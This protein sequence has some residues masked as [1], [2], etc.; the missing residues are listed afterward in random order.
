MSP[1][2]LPP[3]LPANALRCVN[4]VLDVVVP[5]TEFEYALQ[6][7]LKTIQ[8]MREV[9]MPGGVLVLAD[10]GMGKTLLLQVLKRSLSVDDPLLQTSRPV[11]EISL[12]SAAD[13]HQV[14][15]KMLHAVGYEMLPMRATL[16]NMTALVDTAIDR[17]RPC[18]MF[19]DEGQHVCEGN[20]QNVARTLTDWLKVRMDKHNLPVIMVGTPTLEGIAA[21]NPQFVSRVSLRFV[22]NSF[23]YGEEWRRVLSAIVL[24][25]KSLDLGGLS[26][27]GLSR[28][29]HEAARGNLRRLKKLLVFSCVRAIEG[30]SAALKLEHLAEGYVDAFGAAPDAPN[31]FMAA[32]EKSKLKAADKC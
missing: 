17:L 2:D 9:R 28:L 20:R 15:A 14:A 16:L 31:P 27:A 32:I 12:D 5:H 26:G 23:P 19:I 13:V 25:I 11:L 3:R 10:A 18:V 7:A 21:I 24:A 1:F 30:S 22:L 8:W 4:E 6:G 29:M